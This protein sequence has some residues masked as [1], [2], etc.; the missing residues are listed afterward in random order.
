MPRGRTVRRS[1]R[2]PGSVRSKL[3]Y[4]V[5][6]GRARSGEFKRF[7][8]SRAEPGRRLGSQSRYH[9]ETEV[10]SMRS[11]SRA[12]AWQRPP[13]A[14]RTTLLAKSVHWRR[15]R[16]FGSGR[17]KPSARLLSSPASGHQDQAARKRPWLRGRVRPYPDRPL[18]KTG[19]TRLL[20][21]ELSRTPRQ[22]R[23]ST[24]GSS[25]RSRRNDSRSGQA[26]I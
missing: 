21:P 14:M 3:P 15:G 10:T 2:A 8:W 5:C 24:R 9:R 13:R 25:T 17:L 6:F 26:R 23:V 12:R 4:L 22:V 18:L 19:R 7:T 11:G 16:S 20:I 1:L